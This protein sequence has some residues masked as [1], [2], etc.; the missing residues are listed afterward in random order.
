[1]SQVSNTVDDTVAVPHHG[2]RA[3]MLRQVM[4][5]LQCGTLTIVTPDGTR[6]TRRTG[7]PGPEAT[8][9][10]H[11]WR[12]LRRLL[13]DG[14]VGFGEAYIDGD[15]SSPD[16]SAVIEIAARN[17]A[18]LSK[19]I[20]GTRL[21]QWVNRVHH[22]LH[23]NTRRGSRRNI[24]HHYDL[25][26]EF[27]ARWLD[28][29]MTYSSA[30]YV[31][32][33]MTL[34]EAQAAKQDRALA[35]LFPPGG[36][37]VG[38]RVLEIGCGWG[39]IAERLVALGCKVVGLTLS[40]SQLAHARARLEATGHAERA[41]LRLQDYR[42]ASGTFDG[43]ISI[44]M[45]EAVGERYWPAYF[46]ALRARLKPTGRAVLQVITIAEERLESYRSAP[47]FIQ[48]YIFPGGMLPT[49]SIMRHEIARAGLRLLSL[50]TFGASYVRTL[51]EWRQRFAQAWP[52]IAAMGFPDRF[53]RMW[54]YYLHYC[55][56][57]F[58]AGAIDVGLWQIAH[59]D[60][61][62]FGGT[63]EGTLEGAL[64]GTR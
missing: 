27:Y 44:E 32:D 10:L 19:R 14:D 45:L 17:H 62:G 29:G 64:E 35:L 46:D 8:L 2:V 25:G 11:R 38:A 55:E 41:D 40:P 20:N 34:A 57:G 52:E 49:K 3:W 1:M 12:T 18:S 6:A 24:V 61:S 5:P 53:R 26:N 30:L 42:D 7:A 59:D 22:R 47:D 33:D 58:R 60:P 51:A 50:E 23:P 15:W 28:P 16:V 63:L 43:I 21:A 13:F 48:R 31:R 39:G 37:P 36:P 9:V 56:G 4:S 54:E